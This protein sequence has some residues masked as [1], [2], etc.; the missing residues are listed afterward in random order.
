VAD[1]LDTGLVTLAAEE[2]AD[3]AADEDIDVTLLS[4]EDT[5]PLLDEGIVVA[6]LVAVEAQ[7][8]ADGRFVTPELLQRFC[9]YVV[10]ASWSAA[11]H[12]PTRQHA[13]ELKKL[14]FEQMQAI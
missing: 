4:T 5:V 1:V 10:A 7:E 3:E 13:I 8:T 2:A 11:S 12:T 14:A 6:L 9:A